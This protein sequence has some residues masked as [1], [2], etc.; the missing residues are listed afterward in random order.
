MAKE[1]KYARLLAGWERMLAI[2]EGKAEG[3][4]V[5]ALLEELTGGTLPEES[6]EEG[7]GRLQ[8]DRR[9]EKQ[10]PV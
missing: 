7:G 5:L 8:R 9:L 6:G 2:V 1:S 10:V 3:F 4:P